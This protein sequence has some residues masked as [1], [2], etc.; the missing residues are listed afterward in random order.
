MNGGGALA[1][2][3]ERPWGADCPR[4][5]IRPVRHGKA[6]PAASAE[7]WRANAWLHYSP[8]AIA[9]GGLCSRGLPPHTR[10]G[11]GGCTNRRTFQIL[12]YSSLERAASLS[13]APSPAG[14]WCG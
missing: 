6:C 2:K 3:A 7:R 4:G 9:L 13:S 14:G 1:D 8:K 10:Q 11:T 12:P 5:K